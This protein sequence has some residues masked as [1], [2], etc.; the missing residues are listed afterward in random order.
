QQ[1]ALQGATQSPTMVPKEEGFGSCG[2]ALTIGSKTRVQLGVAERLSR[3]L[4]S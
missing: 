2:Y 4:S 1:E 3:F